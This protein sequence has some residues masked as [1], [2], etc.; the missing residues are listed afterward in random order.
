MQVSISELHPFVA[1]AHTCEGRYN[2]HKVHHIYHPEMTE[3]ADCDDAVINSADAPQ[4]KYKEA[5]FTVLCQ[6]M[7]T[8]SFQCLPKAQYKPRSFVQRRLDQS[9]C[10]CIPEKKIKKSRPHYMYYLS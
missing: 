10:S 1:P 2:V 7:H 5:A 8:I 9:V 6:Q 3:K 4:G